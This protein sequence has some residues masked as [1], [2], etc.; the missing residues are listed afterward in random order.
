MGIDPGLAA[1]ARVQSGGPFPRSRLILDDGCIYGHSRLKDACPDL[2]ANASTE[3]ECRSN[4][5]HGSSLA[6]QPPA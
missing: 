6:D 3:R 5:L 1:G 2:R 4:S